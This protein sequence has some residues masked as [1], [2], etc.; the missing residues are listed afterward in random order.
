MDT[1][2][3]FLPAREKMRYSFGLFLAQFY[4]KHKIVCNGYRNQNKCFK[5]M[6]LIITEF[7]SLFALCIWQKQIKWWMRI[8]YE[9]SILKLVYGGNTRLID[10]LAIMSHAKFLP[11]FT[12]LFN[13]HITHI[14]ILQFSEWREKPGILWKK[15]CVNDFPNVPFR[16]GKEKQQ[17]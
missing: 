5:N 11:F 17:E 10:R 9:L 6:R 1:T 14:T 13:V 2:P 8:W 15:G 16:R 4:C 7:F 12:L 3:S